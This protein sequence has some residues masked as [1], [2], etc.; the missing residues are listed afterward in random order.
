M[1]KTRTIL[2]EKKLPW[3][4][5]PR[6]GHY[7]DDN[8]LFVLE[9]VTRGHLIGRN[10]SNFF[11]IASYKPLEWDHK[12]LI[13]FLI[14]VVEEYGIELKNFATM[15]YAF[16]EE[17]EKPTFDE[18]TGKPFA[19]LEK[20][21][22]KYSKEYKKYEE[23]RK[24]HN[25]KPDDFFS[26]ECPF[27][28]QSRIYGGAYKWALDEIKKKPQTAEGRMFSKIFSDKF[29][30]PDLKEALKISETVQRTQMSF[31]QKRFATIL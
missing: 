14:R 19:G 16:A 12:T 23:C 6:L 11:F 25:L 17:Y 30:L 2:Q 8:A 31:S 18:K 27:P 1:D 29:G 7:I 28:I 4:D 5:D 15:T 10:A 24:K 26:R 13:K 20:A 3:D 9:S 21:W 22:E